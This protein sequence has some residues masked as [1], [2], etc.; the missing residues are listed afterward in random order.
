MRLIGYLSNEAEARQFVDFLY[1]QRIESRTDPASDGRWEVWI[2]DD[3]NVDTAREQLSR[4]SLSPNDP[5]F[6]QAA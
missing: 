2:I 6:Q 5:I 1:S 4:F 3:K